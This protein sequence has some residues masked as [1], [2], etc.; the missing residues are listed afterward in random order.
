MQL[1]TVRSAHRLL[2]AP[3]AASLRARDITLT[4]ASGRWVGPHS[5]TDDETLTIPGGSHLVL[6]N[7][8]D[9]AILAAIEDLAWTSEA[10]SA[11]QV[12]TMQ[13]FRDL[14]SSEILSPQ[15][16]LAVSHIAFLFSAL[17]TAGAWPGPRRG[18]STQTQVRHA[19]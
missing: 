7:Q 14:F 8:T 16:Q 2:L 19:A 3:G 18:A 13:E 11:A 10:T 17:M 15:Q 12:T 5:L 1:R 6:R 9:G 4:Y